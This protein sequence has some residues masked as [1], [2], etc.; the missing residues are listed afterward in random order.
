[1]KKYILFDNDGVLVETEPW[2]LKA[3]QK[4]LKEFFNF[5]FTK[6]DYMKLMINGGSVWQGVEALGASESKVNI[7][8]DKRN[9]YYQEYLQNED[10]EISG[11]QDILKKLSQK[12]KMAIVTT[13]RRVD[14][15]LIHKN[16]GIV[17]YMDFVLC[18]SDYTYAKPHPMPY[19]TAM[20]KFKAIQSE[21]IVVEDSKRG[22]R[23]AIAAKIDCA[24]VYNEFT[25]SQDFTEASYKI[26]NLKDLE[27]LL[28]DLEK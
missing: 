24:I 5:D 22:L 2:Y 28:K 21:C 7:A 20:E 27:V 19:L 26:K 16:R 17:D 18:E 8:R 14:F 25:T 9:E 11:V 1:M 23:S 12:Y 10:I 13:S 4:S 3:S 6:D 15:E